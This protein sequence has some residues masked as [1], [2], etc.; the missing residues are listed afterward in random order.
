M[1]LSLLV[2]AAL[3]AGCASQQPQERRP[4]AADD[5][6]GPCYASLATDARFAP[7]FQ[8]TPQL[9]SDMT[10]EMSTDTSVATADERGILSLYTAARQRCVHLG[11]AFRQTYG[12]PGW[13]AAVAAFNAKTMD[14]YADL[15]SGKQTWGEFNR[16][17]RELSTQ[18]NAQLS[19]LDRRDQQARSQSAEVA[20]QNAI[21][22][23]L[24]FKSM[25][26]APAV[27]CTSRQIGSTAYTS[28][29]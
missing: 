23:Y 16:H 15:Y 8:K 1:K 21:S 19:E 17:R 14:S 7:M 13:A 26:P 10:L 27:N 6:S 11:E 9:V 5:P 4:T 12:P 28:C 25:Q 18:I 3:L 20:R 22:N 24:L 2:C 29:Q